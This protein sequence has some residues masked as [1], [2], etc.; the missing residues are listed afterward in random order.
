M[1]ILIIEDEFILSTALSE[2]LENEGY[3]VVNVVDDGK[4]AL[5]FYQKNE[6]DLILCDISINGDWDGIETVENIIAHKPVPIIYLT[7]LSDKETIE[8]AKKTF[9]AAY[10]PKPFHV[11][12]LRMAIEMAINNFAVKIQPVQIL[13]DEK[14]ENGLKETILQVND[15][16]F[17]KQNYQFVKFPLSDILYLEA[18]KTYTTIVTTQKKY[19]IKLTISHVLERFPTKNL[20]RIHRSYAININKIESFNEQDVTINGV[21]IPLGRSFK[22]DFMKC[23][24]FR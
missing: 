21:Q 12:N 17:I 10:I 1:K 20:V 19:A 22:E 14:P 18:D 24:M 23:F 3:E 2:L 11:D 8:R 6:V 4:D 5:E 16:I 15:D 7:A 13:R 9:P